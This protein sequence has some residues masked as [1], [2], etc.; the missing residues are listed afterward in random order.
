M[1]RI[2]YSPIGI[3]HSPHKKATGI[4][5]QSSMAMD[6]QGVIELFPEFSKGLTDLEDFSHLI[7]IYHFHKSNGYELLVRPFL[8]DSS[9]GIFCTRAPIRPNSIGLSVVRLLI[10]ESSSIFF[11]G[12]DMLDQTPLLD[13]KPYISD[14]DSFEDCVMGWY[15]R[16][17]TKRQTPLSDDRFINND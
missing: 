7:L 14:F 6:V 17:N 16:K 9:H 10:I 13:I 5:I 8:D 2:A 12:N 3:I 1:K 11:S 4:P 15:D